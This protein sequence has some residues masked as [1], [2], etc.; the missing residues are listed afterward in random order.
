MTATA[1]LSISRFG[2]L[3]GDGDY[4]H[5]GLSVADLRDDRHPQAK[6]NVTVRFSAFRKGLRVTILADYKKSRSNGKA[7]D[8]ATGFCPPQGPVL[9]RLY[10][11]PRAP[12]QS[13]I[14]SKVKGA[15]KAR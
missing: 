12:E 13:A 10:M 2:L 11:S 7:V 6:G 1:R 14:H 15:A 9:L 8:C 3:A 5:T 4:E